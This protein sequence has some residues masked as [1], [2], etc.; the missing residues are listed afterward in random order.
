MHRGGWVAGI[1]PEKREAQYKNNGCAHFDSSWVTIWQNTFFLLFS[2][3]SWCDKIFGKGK[4]LIG[5][6]GVR[7]VG[8][9]D[10][11]GD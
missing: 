8:C 6:A 11:P 7:K 2:C 3:P 10:C 1:N 5:V 9:A 4:K